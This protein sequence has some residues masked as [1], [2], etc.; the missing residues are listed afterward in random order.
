MRLPLHQELCAYEL[1][2]VVDA[3]LDNLGSAQ[4]PANVSSGPASRDRRRSDG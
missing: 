2:R 3:V 4:R 1:K